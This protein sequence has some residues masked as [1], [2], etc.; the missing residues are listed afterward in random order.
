MPHARPR[1]RRAAAVDLVMFRALD[2]IFCFQNGMHTCNFASRGWLL[3][4][5]WSCSPSVVSSPSSLFASHLHLDYRT[6]P[7]DHYTPSRKVPVHSTRLTPLTRLFPID[8][9]Q[10]PRLIPNA[11]AWPPVSPANTS[12]SSP[13]RPQNLLTT[14]VSADLEDL[15]S[16]A[17]MQG[18]LHRILVRLA[19]HISA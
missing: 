16:I 7:R 4:C 10:L 6:T 13:P 19:T 11:D 12:Y 3:K 8:G 17:E 18:P 2:A 15:C 5:R 14:A 9:L 1:A